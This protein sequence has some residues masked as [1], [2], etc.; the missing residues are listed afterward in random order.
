MREVAHTFAGVEHRLE[1]TG[2]KDGVRW[3]NDSIAS[4]PTRAIAGLKCFDTPVI[5]IAGGYD[6]NL[7]FDELGQVIAS[8]DIKLLLC[9]ATASKIEKAVREASGGERV[10]IETLQNLA[11]TVARAHALAQPGDTVL[12]S[13]SCASFDQFPDFRRRGETFKQLVRS[14][15]LS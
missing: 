8:R 3:Y 7:P 6:K 9:G 15:I 13:P 5:L 10:H 1:L 4:S 14:T 2:E 11:D 12:F